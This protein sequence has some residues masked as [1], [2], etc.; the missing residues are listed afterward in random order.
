MA[1]HF[2]AEL[3]DSYHIYLLVCFAQSERKLYEHTMGLTVFA[4]GQ[5][6]N[7]Y[8]TFFILRQTSTVRHMETNNTQASFCHLLLTRPNKT[9][10]HKNKTK[11][12]ETTVIRRFQTDSGFPCFPF[13]TLFLFHKINT[14]N[15][16]TYCPI[17]LVGDNKKCP[18]TN[19]NYSPHK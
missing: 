16:Y 4:T 6:Y 3:D 17:Y 19:K 8:V 10:Q 12:N 15:T 7:P 14:G 1:F 13:V 9:K 5:K 2:R 18:Q 11:R